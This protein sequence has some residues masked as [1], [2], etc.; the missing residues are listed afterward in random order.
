MNPK[1]Q[2]GRSILEKKTVPQL[3]ESLRKLEGKG[4]GQGDMAKLARQVL[5]E[6]RIREQGP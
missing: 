3:E 2:Y 5:Q 4:L 6:K 1:E